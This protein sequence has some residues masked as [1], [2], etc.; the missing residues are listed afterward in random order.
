MN[1][2]AISTSAKLLRKELGSIDLS[3]ISALREE[4]LNDEELISRAIDTE[5]FYT[6]YFKKV[7]ALFVQEQLEYI[8][9]EALNDTQFIFGRG[10][11]NGFLLIDKW[12]GEQVSMARERFNKEEPSE[13]GEL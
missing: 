5:L 2:Q 4:G 8:G 1:Q 7:L 12:F 3:E 10:T 13:P 11:I 9:K 6:K